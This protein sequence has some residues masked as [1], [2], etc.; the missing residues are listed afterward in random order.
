MLRSTEFRT[1]CTDY[2]KCIEAGKYWGQSNV[3]GAKA[4]V[5]EYRYLSKALEQELLLAL[6]KSVET[7]D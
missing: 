2:G 6:K 4:K 5:Q 1:L 3:P 7:L